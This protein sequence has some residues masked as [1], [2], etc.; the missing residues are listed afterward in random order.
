[1][2]RTD[3]GPQLT[4]PVDYFPGDTL[5]TPLERA[6]GLPIGNQT[7]QFFGPGI[8]AQL[9]SGWAP[10]STM[11]RVPDKAI[12]EKNKARDEAKKKV[13]ALE[14][15][16]AGAGDSRYRSA[17]LSAPRGGVGDAHPRN[18]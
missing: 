2:K 8:F 4:P 3:N 15:Q 1:M 17:A 10:V 12:P 13:P 9:S 16:I 11:K 18:P 14:A 6:R 5:F 7:S